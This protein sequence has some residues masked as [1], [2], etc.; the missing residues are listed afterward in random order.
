LVRDG[1]SWPGAGEVV[2]VPLGARRERERRCEE[3][4]EGGAARVCYGVA[5]RLKGRGEAGGRGEGWLRWWRTTAPPRTWRARCGGGRRHAKKRHRTVSD[6]GWNRP[7]KKKDG[8]GEV[9]ELGLAGWSCWASERGERI[10]PP[11]V[12][13]Q[14]REGLGL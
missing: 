13:V 7:K 1:R 2:L 9:A 14:G 11:E 4:K 6:V 10:G 8:R 3:G 12:W 5:D